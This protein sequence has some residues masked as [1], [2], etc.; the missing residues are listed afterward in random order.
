MVKTGLYLKNIGDRPAINELWSEFFGET[1]PSRF[2]VQVADIFGGADLTNILVD[3]IAI[4]PVAQTS[5]SP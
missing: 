4:A 5:T 2:G 3:A 1:P